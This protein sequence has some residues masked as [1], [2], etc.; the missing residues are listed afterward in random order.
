MS[1]GFPQDIWALACTIYEVILKTQLFSEYEDYSSLIRQMESWFGPLPIEYRNIAKA[2]L[3]RDKKRLLK[4]PDEQFAN[5]TAIIPE[6]RLSDPSQPLSLSPDEDQRA[7]DLFMKGTDWSNPLQASLGE[8]RVCY[9]YEKTKIED[10]SSDNTD[11]ESSDLDSPSEDEGSDMNTN[12]NT[13]SEADLEA[14]ESQC[15]MS[16]HS[17]ETNEEQN[18]PTLKTPTTPMDLAEQSRDEQRSPILASQMGTKEL[19]QIHDID[20]DEENQIKSPS[21]PQKS[22]GKRSESGSSQGKEAK[23]R[24]I[25]KDL[26]QEKDELVERLVCMPSEEVLL[27]SDLLMRMFKHDPKERIDINTVVNHEY[28]GDRRSN[29][30]KKHEDLGEE[31]PDPI[32]SRTRSRVARAQ[33]QVELGST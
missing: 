1:S 28:W 12:M 13:Q 14:T 4:L 29:W 6:D 31:I 32:S 10:S 22:P 20:E 2:H 18:S 11:S 3:E 5:S 17:E 7:K 8:E 26:K 25:S 15:L 19:S 27:L 24:R 33:Q 9:V 21:S 16:E 23:R 30:G